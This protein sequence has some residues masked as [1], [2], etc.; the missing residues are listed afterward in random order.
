ME[1]WALE[2]A[3]A[4]EGD[5]RDELEREGR[6]AEVAWADEQQRSRRPEETHPPL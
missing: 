3:A 4:R 1:D 6:G 2:L 5:V